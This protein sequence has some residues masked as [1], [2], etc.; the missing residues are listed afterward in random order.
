MLVILSFVPVSNV[1]SE[2][3]WGD[4]KQF[5]NDL[6]NG[7]VTDQMG[8]NIEEMGAD[9][10][11]S[12]RTPQE[13]PA[14]VGTALDH[15]RNE[16]K[17]MRTQ[18]LSELYESYPATRDDIKRAV[19]YAVFSNVAVN[20]GFLGGGGGSGIV[21]DNRNG[22]DTYMKMGSLGTGWGLGIKDFRQ[23]LIFNTKKDFDDFIVSGWNAGV[24][25]DAVVKGGEKG[26]DAASGSEL[27]GVDSYQ[28]NKNG[29][30]LSAMINAYKYWPDDDLN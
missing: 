7:K 27:M 22:N 20:L 13:T 28:F 4:I 23:I 6:G 21:H 3:L 29:I 11:E 26:G 1:F 25:A 15:Q 16:L 12:D 8:S 5:G 18:T 19:G 2:G 10:E 14:S 17:T 9:S 24:E 30:S